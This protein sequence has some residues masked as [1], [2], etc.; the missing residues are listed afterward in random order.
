VTNTKFITTSS[1]LRQQPLHICCVVTVF[2]STVHFLFTKLKK[3]FESLF[4][5]NNI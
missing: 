2:L 3:L 1:Q 4:S 5:V